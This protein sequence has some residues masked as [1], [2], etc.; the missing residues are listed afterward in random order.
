MSCE[1]AHLDGAYVLGSLTPTERLRYEAH[2]PGCPEC[3]RSVRELAGMPGL[4]SQ[5]DAADLEVPLVDAPLPPTLLPSLVRAAR[6]AQRR[7]S[8][9]TAAVAAGVAA[10]VS[11]VAVGALA[12]D[13]GEGQ[14]SASPSVVAT[15]R[16][17][18]QAMA[19][20]GATP[21]R[22]SV[23]MTSVA[24]GTRLDLTCSYGTSTERYESSGGAPAYALVV[25][26]R[27]EGVEQVGTW[28]PLP[29]RTMH[30]SA[31]TASRRDDITTVE[32]RDATG[33]VV[34]TLSS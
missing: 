34:L 19:P 9:A 24:W 15:S 12:L 18:E 23:A 13:R 5:V 6:G 29:G 32:V 31:G 27:D 17:V 30:L 16:P 7:R 20:V 8:V 10:A 28:R 25:R 26:T 4:L 21:V 3:S 33:T 14:P 22:A 11:A 2:L 1:L